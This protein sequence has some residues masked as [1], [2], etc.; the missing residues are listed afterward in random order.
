M[1]GRGLGKGTSRVRTQQDSQRESLEP[2]E[3]WTHRNKRT[4]GKAQR[5]KIHDRAFR[6]IYEWSI[7]VIFI[8]PFF[9]LVFWFIEMSTPHVGWL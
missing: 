1:R 4:T 6:T 7:N 5:W 2:N 3:T 9:L 8:I